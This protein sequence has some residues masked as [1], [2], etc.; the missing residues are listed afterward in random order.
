MCIFKQKIH[1]LVS[2]SYTTTCSDVG[3]EKF[4]YGE[5]GGQDVPLFVPHTPYEELAR[6]I[7]E[8]DALINQGRKLRFR[9]W[10]AVPSG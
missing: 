2:F 1:A 10:E 6:R 8:K 4:G 7:K 5:R 3:R 9:T